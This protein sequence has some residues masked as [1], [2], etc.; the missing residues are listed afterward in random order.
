M[1]RTKIDE[2][3]SLTRYERKLMHSSNYYY[4]N[5]EKILLKQKENYERKKIRKN[6]EW[7]NV[8]F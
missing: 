4:K 7:F 1:E 2:T 5:R 8:D 3:E 6:P